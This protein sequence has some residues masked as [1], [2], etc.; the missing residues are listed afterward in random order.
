MT[1]NHKHKEWR[2]KI[3][4]SDYNDAERVFT[5]IE[6]DGERADIDFLLP[7]IF[8]SDSVIAHAHAVHSA[9]YAVRKIVERLS[10]N[11]Q[12]DAILHILCSQIPD[13][14]EASLLISGA[15]GFVAIATHDKVGVGMLTPDVSPT[16]HADIQAAVNQKSPLILKD[17]SM[18]SSVC[19]IVPITVN[20]IVIG[21]FCVN[22]RIQAGTPN[23]LDSEYPYRDNIQYGI[24]MFTSFLIREFMSNFSL[25]AASPHDLR[26]L[27][28]GIDNKA[29]P[30]AVMNLVLRLTGI[31]HVTILVP[32]DDG[33]RHLV[34]SNP[35]IAEGKVDSFT[36]SNRFYALMHKALQSG[37]TFVSN[38]MFVQDQSK[39]SIG[40]M[41]PYL[42]IMMMFPLRVGDNVYGLLYF[43][44]SIR[45]NYLY[46]STTNTD[47]ELTPNSF[48][49]SFQAACDVLTP[50][51]LPML[52]R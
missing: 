17:A 23:T 34:S 10:E 37:D 4:H 13:Y 33:F 19:L 41:D 36:S 46:L 12:A 5:R 24:G 31:K 32:T 8:D 16:K 30:D 14:Q 49:K 11:E 39:F 26:K 51:L 2:N 47:R 50:L 9:T 18:P 27:F 28:S 7:Y 40:I 22:Q 38:T 25:P 20:Q 45:L 42:G 52:T 15:D 43:D 48:I 44:F 6:R 1:E 21:L 3:A 29:L 35:T